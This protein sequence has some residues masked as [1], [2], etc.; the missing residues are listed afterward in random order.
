MSK[1]VEI[2]EANF[3]EEVLQSNIPVI[4]DFWA[5]GCGP[6]KMIA[7]IMEEIAEEYDGKVKVGK[8]DVNNNPN[9]AVKYGIRSIPTVLYFK[10]GKVVQQIIGAYPKSH[11]IDKLESVLQ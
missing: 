6:C 3:E 1:P 2:T 8:L 9:I 11:F 7:P 4:I 10:D 5:V